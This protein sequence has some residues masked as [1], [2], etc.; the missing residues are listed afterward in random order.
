MV[1]RAN[2]TDSFPGANQVA[3]APFSG[4]DC[5]LF[6]TVTAL[7]VRLGELG[8]PATL[9]AGQLFFEQT[10]AAL[11]TMCSGVDPVPTGSNPDP[12]ENGVAGEVTGTDFG[13][14]EGRVLL[15]N[16]STH[17]AS[18]IVVEQTVLVW[19]D[20]DVD[21]TAV[22]GGLPGDPVAVWIFVENACGRISST[23]KAT[24]IFTV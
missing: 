2:D 4:A 13:A 19:T 14:S 23:G 21:F 18:S 10:D 17:A 1:L 5:C 22:Q 7:A 24:T 3:S 11:L 9:R 6:P 15:G 12:L 16:A 8:I 20:T